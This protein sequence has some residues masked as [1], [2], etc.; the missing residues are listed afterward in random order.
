MI[1]CIEFLLSRKAVNEQAAIQAAEVWRELQSICSVNNL[2]RICSSKIQIVDPMFGNNIS[3]DSR[4]SEL[5]I[6]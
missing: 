3:Y 4:E 2:A 6:I 5:N 1:I